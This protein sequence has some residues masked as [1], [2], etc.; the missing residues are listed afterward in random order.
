MDSIGFTEGQAREMLNILF[1]FHDNNIYSGA[2][3][4]LLDII[5][6]IK[7]NEGVRITAIVPTQSGDVYA[8]LEK[9]GV[10]AIASNYYSLFVKYPMRFEDYLHLPINFLRYFQTY[11]AAYKVSKIVKNT[12]IVYNNTSVNFMGL[13]IHKFLNNTKLIWHIR[14]FCEEDQSIMPLFGRKRFVQNLNKADNIIFISKT[15]QNKYKEMIDLDKSHVLFND[16]S[17]R[18]INMCDRKENNRLNI[19]IAGR[20]CEEKGQFDAIKAV[21]MAID[22]GADVDLYLAGS[23]RE[24]AYYNTINDYIHVNQLEDRV[25]FLGMVKNLKDIRREMDIGIVASKME[26]F[27]RVTIEGMLSKM[28]II[29]ADCGGTAELIKNNETGFLY[30]NNDV[31]K[32][33]QIIIALYTDRKLL[34]RIQVSG[35]EYALQFTEGRTA[36]AIEKLMYESCN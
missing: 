30:R 4:S 29:G 35:Y 24:D 2:S 22:S 28:C 10:K 23:Y 21:K 27:G 36:H 33:S 9:I 7:K 19:L 11:F 17:P 25:H 8:Y 34:R 13:F 5:E 32:M 15:L 14:E 26:A 18:N 16:I 1:V 12:N 6:T 20:V 31:E 3:R